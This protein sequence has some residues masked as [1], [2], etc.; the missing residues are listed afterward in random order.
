MHRA[1]L[2]KNDKLH[3]FAELLENVVIQTVESGVLTKDLAII[4]HKTNTYF[5]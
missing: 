1:N 4:I 5:F 2:D 3:K